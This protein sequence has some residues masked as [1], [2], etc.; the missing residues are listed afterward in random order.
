MELI[1][2]VRSF[3]LVT[4]VVRDPD[5]TNRFKEVNEFTFCIYISVDQAKQFRH[6]LD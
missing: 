5:P 1:I 3:V 2:D 4:S 6:F